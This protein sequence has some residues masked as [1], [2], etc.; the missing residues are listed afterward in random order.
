MNKLFLI[1]AFLSACGSMVAQSNKKQKSAHMKIAMTAEKWNCP[2]GTCEFLQHDG[3]AAMRVLNPKDTVVLK[4]FTFIN[5]TIEYDI[6]PLD[7]D[8]AG[9]FFRRRNGLESEQFYLRVQYGTII[10]SMISVQYA[11]TIQGVNLWALL[12]YYQG[13]ATVA[14][15]KWNHIKLVVSG[16]QMILYVNDLTRPALE[17][18]MLEGNTLEGGLAFNGKAIISNL[19][20]KAEDGEGL[21]QP[22]C[23][24]PVSND[25]RYLRQWQVTK[26]V[27]FPKGRDLSNNDFPMPESSWSTLVAERRGL[28][29]LTRSFGKSEGRR[30]VWLRCKLRVPEA[31]IRKVDFGF[32]GEVWIFLNRKYALVDK[33]IFDA[34][35]R[36]Q[37]RARCSIENTSFELNMVS[38]ENEILIGISNDSFGWGIMARLDAMDG[39]EVIP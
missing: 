13:N 8:I 20:I 29:N 10:N 31:Q 36:K 6:E 5:G 39:I 27:D 37:P 32:T 18:G 4:D 2:N 21:S 26:P 38:G 16:K 33:N 3:V 1:L 15:G 30:M 23:F 28:I 35:I 17:V 24:D 19:V 14:M 25:P 22:S 11:P 9:F 12:P 34:A 7:K